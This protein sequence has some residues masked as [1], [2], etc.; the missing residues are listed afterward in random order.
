[1]VEWG[2]SDCHIYKVYS[3]LFLD[4]KHWTTR[5]LSFPPFFFLF[6]LCTSHHLTA[7]GRYGWV[8]ANIIA[9]NK[10]YRKYRMYYGTQWCH[11]HYFTYNNGKVMI[12][13]IIKSSEIL[14]WS[15]IMIVL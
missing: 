14:R 9:C 11:L 8:P 6:F 12:R 7:H 13:R 10:K 1:M 5:I 4:G 2:I 3:S 15:K